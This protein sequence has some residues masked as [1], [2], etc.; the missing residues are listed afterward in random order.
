MPHSKT[1]QLLISGGDERLALNADGLNKYGCSPCPDDDEVLAFSSST[2]TPISSANFAI[3]DTL[4][5]HLEQENFSEKIHHQEMHRQKATWR[6]LIDLEESTR[7]IF[8]P[9]GTDL[10]HLVSSQMASNS[11]VIMIEGN[12]TGSGVACALTQNNDVEVV[13]ISLRF[14][15]GL[16]R[17]ISQID[18]EV[19]ALAQQAISQNRDVLLILADQSKTGMIAPSLNCAMS[20]KN[21]FK[22][23]LNVLVDACQFRL[24]NATLK[25]YLQQNFMIALTGS[26]FLAA[27]SFSAMLILPSSIEFTDK[28]E[29]I[30]FG[31]L[32][33][34]EIALHQ[35]RIFCTLTDAQIQTVIGDFTKSIS[36]YL[37]NSPHFELLE[38]PILARNTCNWDS[39]PTIFPFLLLRDNEPLSI[40]QMREIYQQLPLQNPRCQLGQPVILGEEKSALRLCLS[41]PLIVQAA[42]SE[43]HRRACIEKALR[44]LATLERII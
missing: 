39:L 44:V 21:Q 14:A 36:H 4:R 33:R 13:A 26:K 38:M 2:A 29:E 6:E 42:Q 28:P 22:N 24:C 43:S 1:A 20:L 9:S 12:E 7:I 30:N 17:P 37:N 34:M 8:S 19:I 35:Y 31:L 10:H 15:N 27:P 23:R 40:T 18:A 16:P 25:N 5:L 41:A 3:A 11:L 32:L